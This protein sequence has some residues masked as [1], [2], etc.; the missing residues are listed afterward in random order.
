MNDRTTT[1]RTMTDRTTTGRT[2]VR[3]GAAMHDRQLHDPAWARECSW[4]DDRPGEH[5]YRCPDLPGKLISPRCALCPFGMP[6]ALRTPVTRMNG[7]PVA[8]TEREYLR[9]HRDQE[10]RKAMRALEKVKFLNAA[11]DAAPD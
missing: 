1:G 2:T 6:D 7:D 11:L 8:Q 4:E 10:T 5:L 9:K 3:Q